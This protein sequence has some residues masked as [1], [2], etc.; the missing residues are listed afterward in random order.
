MKYAATL[1][2]SFIIALLLTAPASAQQRLTGTWRVQEVA[3]QKT[4]KGVELSF[5][6]V[7][8]TKAT[9]TYRLSDDAPQTW[10]FRFTMDQGQLK[11]EPAK[12]QGEPDSITYDIRFEEGKL[13]L[14]T[15]KPAEETDADKPAEGAEDK[16]ADAADTAADPAQPKP[17]ADKPAEQ[18]D[19]ASTAKEEPS[20]A[21]DTEKE[22]EETEKEKDQPDTREPVWVLTPAE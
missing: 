18:G 1:L 3:G 2:A 16:P 22:Q 7:D 10:D 12:V 20:S 5:T 8:D 11:L 17:D 6:F 14:L 21:T 15:P 4:P 9:L 19:P 13:L